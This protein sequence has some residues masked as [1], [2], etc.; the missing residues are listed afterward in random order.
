MEIITSSLFSEP[1]IYFSIS[2]KVDLK[3]R[4]ILNE[5]LKSKLEQITEREIKYLNLMVSTNCSTVKTEVKGP[6]LNRREQILNWGIWLPYKAIVES[7][8]Q[9]GRYISYYFDALVSLF[10]QYEIPEEMIRVLQNEV[11][12]EVL[13]NPEYDYMEESID[14]D[15]SELKF[16]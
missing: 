14:L 3:I 2:H 10:G 12:T 4:G 9:K 7:S 1:N 5:N 16:D 11:E 13:N 6:D 8:D 15:L